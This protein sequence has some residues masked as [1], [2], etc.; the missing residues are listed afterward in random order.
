[1]Q[2]SAIRQL[3]RAVAAGSRDGVQAEVAILGEQA[4]LSLLA[5]SISFGHGRLAV[6]RL[7]MAVQAGADVPKDHWIYC[8]E[9]A[10]RS[11]DGRLRDMFLEAAHA[12]AS[13]EAS[14]VGIH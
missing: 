11:Q 4:A 14:M 6:I 13:R 10:T 8:R 9:A 1:M 2:R 5:R 7:A 3:K 12:A